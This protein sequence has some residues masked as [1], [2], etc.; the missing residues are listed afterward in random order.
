[1]TITGDEILAQFSSFGY[2]PTRVMQYMIS[3]QERLR[4]GEQLYVDP[5]SPAVEIMEMYALMTHGAILRNEA[6][7]Y[8]SYPNMSQTVGDLRYH[9]TDRDYVGDFTT[10]GG[11]WFDIYVA[12]DELVSKAVRV[13]NSKTRKL[14]FPKHS[15]IVVN[16]MTFTFQYPINVIV[17]S[18]NGIDIVYDISRPSPLQQMGGNVVDWGVVTTPLATDT[19]GR[20]R[21]VWMRVYL[22]QMGLSTTVHSVSDAKILKK[23]LALSDNFFFV[24]AFNRNN[25]KW[26]EM[27]TTNSQQVF[28]ASDPTLLY[29]LENDEL[30]IELPYVYN[31]STL[32]NDS[33]RVDVYTTKGPINE[34]F[35]GLTP[36]DFTATWL[37]LDKDDNGIYYA[38]LNTMSTISVFSTD[39]ASGGAAAPTFEAM[40]DRVKNNAIGDPVI[41]ISNAQ[42]GVELANMGFDVDTKIDDITT[43]TYLASKPMPTNTGGRASTGIDSAVITL[44]STLTDLVK[45]KTVVDNTDRITLTP[46]TLYQYVDGVLKIVPDDLREAIDVLEGD[47]KVNKLNGQHYMWTP[48]HYV[49]DF[50]EE[51]FEARPYYLNDPKFGL[52]SYE[53]SNDTLGLTIGS[54]KVKSIVRDEDGYQIDI[55]ATSN[56]TWKELKDEQ[57]HVQL[58][59]VPIGESKLAFVSGT[60]MAVDPGSKER[61]FRFRINTRWD[62]D[63]DHALITTNFSMF[64]AIERKYSTPLSAPFTLVWA[65][66]DYVADGSEPTNIDQV[67][68]TWLLPKGSVGVYQESVI[69]NLG[70][71]LSGLWARCR[72]MIGNRKVLTYEEDVYKKYSKNEYEKDP[73]T[74]QYVI[75]TGSDGKKSLKLLHAKGDLEL[76]PTNGEAIIQH[77]KGYAVLDENGNPVYE[78]D[79]NILRWVDLTLFDAVYRYATYA[80]DVS[81]TASVPNVLVEWINDQLGSLRPNLLAETIMLF[82]PLTTLRYV[83]TRVEDG[84]LKTLHSAQQLT[85]D[86]Y[87]TDDVY[88]DTDLRKSLK[89]S[90]IAQ[91]VAGLNAVTVARNVIE[92]AIT[93]NLGTDIIGVHLSGLGG[94]KNDYNVIVLLDETTRLGLAKALETTADGKYAVVDA[95]EVNFKRNDALGT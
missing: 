17:K 84:E 27:K 63:D 55:M 33:I 10:P 43:L 18:H 82:Q 40:R 49:F 57:V 76:D 25:G 29:T 11:A 54:S 72:S 8:H 30:T 66:S 68:G 80:G 71:E 44:K 52:S 3:I 34:N 36:G 1:M 78:S 24:R 6:I 67:M 20:I 62:I 41:P 90:A 95:I 91:T 5:S 42:L 38:P 56:D 88:K 28:D 15:N 9:K 48:F 26:V 94:L 60:Q 7:D 39:I 83:D 65:V 50:E 2:E 58:G 75:I 4:N 92:K 59:F 69:V 12:E 81:Y 51:K 74:G 37:D 86:L 77:P 32:V 73:V 64:E 93:D 23:T 87:V 61:I 89:A 35:E 79:R 13:G 31:K 46:K 47:A 14:T 45:Y 19:Q 21:M 85:I 22:R 53:D 70:A 16:G